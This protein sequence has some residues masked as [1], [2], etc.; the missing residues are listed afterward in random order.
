MKYAVY[1]ILMIWLLMMG[2]GL[3]GYGIKG[4]ISGLDPNRYGGHP[5]DYA[6]HWVL[7]LGPP[8]LGISYGIVSRARRQ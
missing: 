2:L 1:S 6:V 3:Y 7:L 8:L 5:I 4:L